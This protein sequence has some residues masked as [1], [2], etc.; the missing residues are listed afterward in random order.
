M[1]NYGQIIQRTKIKRGVH[2]VFMNHEKYKRVVA[3]TT[4]EVELKF[5]FLGS[6]LDRR[7]RGGEIRRGLRF[8]QNRQSEIVGDLERMLKTDEN[9]N[10]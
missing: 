4:G 10:D 3:W 1:N 7:Q 8:F 5:I 9:E 6:R 2:V